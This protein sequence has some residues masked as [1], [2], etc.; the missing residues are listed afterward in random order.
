MSTSTSSVNRDILWQRW[1]EPGLE[2]LRV[3]TEAQSI[4]LNGSLVGRF[5]GQVLRAQYEVHTT[6]DFVFRA[7][8]LR[9][10]HPQERFVHLLRSEDGDW[11]GS[12][13]VD[14]AA[15]KGCVDI[16]LAAS[17]STNTLPIRRLALGL[18]ETAE[19]AVAFIEVPS[20]AV[21]REQQRYTLIAREAA[22]NV[23]RFEHL[24]SNFTA[25]ITVDDDGFVVEYPGLF[26]RV[27]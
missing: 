10:T 7:L 22:R 14:A 27:G 12:P 21:R 2:H 20:L 24:A 4:V 8:T 17:P 3:Q 5:D 16:D 25:D 1:D 19:I 13:G 9:L 15:L 26:R 18:G 6:L 11:N 23:Y